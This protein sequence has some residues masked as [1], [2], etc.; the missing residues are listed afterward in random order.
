ML[1][2][3]KDYKGL[4]TRSRRKVQTH[5]HLRGNF[6]CLGEERAPKKSTESLADI[7]TRLLRIAR[8]SPQT[9]R[10]RR[11]ALLASFLLAS[12]PPK[13]LRGG[14]AGGQHPLHHLLESDV[15]ANGDDAKNG[16][17]TWRRRHGQASQ[18]P[19]RLRDIA[20]ARPHGPNVLLLIPLKPRDGEHALSSFP[21]PLTSI[22][23]A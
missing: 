3:N 1:F 21:P 19:F 8:S 15:V 12:P 23:L 6:P 13:T 4:P 2:G 9:A 18:R 14:Q 7:A 17:Q 11:D 16:H 20:E 10:V 5:C 22:L